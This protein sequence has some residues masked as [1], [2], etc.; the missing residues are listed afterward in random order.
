MNYRTGFIRVG[1]VFSNRNFFSFWFFSKR[2]ILT[3]Q[4]ECSRIDNT[5]W[6]VDSFSL[7]ILFYNDNIN[8]NNNGWRAWTWCQL[9]F[10]WVP[11]CIVQLRYIEVYTTLAEPIHASEL[12]Y[13]RIQ[14]LSKR[15]FFAVVDWRSHC[16]YHENSQDP[17]SHA[18]GDRII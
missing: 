3:Q 17:Q 13:E 15:L 14:W 1:T 5:R 9:K 11:H 16:P 7:L 18:P 8:N 6:P 10:L 2:R 12:H 4:S